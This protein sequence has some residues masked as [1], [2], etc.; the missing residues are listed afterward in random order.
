MKKKERKLN[1]IKN[2]STFEYQTTMKLNLIYKEILDIKTIIARYIVDKN[3]INTKNNIE[4]EIH[5]LNCIV[6]SREQLPLEQKQK[7]TSFESI[8]KN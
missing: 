4:K 8:E 2:E 1:N 7:Y 3:I 6:A 5:K